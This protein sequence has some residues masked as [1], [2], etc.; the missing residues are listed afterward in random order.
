M[1]K[2]NVSSVFESLALGE[3]EA[4][5]RHSVRSTKAENLRKQEAEEAP[6]AAGRPRTDRQQFTITLSPKAVEIV[7]RELL[8][9]MQNKDLKASEKKPGPAIEALILEAEAQRKRR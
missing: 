9:R 5:N 3:Q 7:E 6:R 1:K 8:A 4:E 2:P